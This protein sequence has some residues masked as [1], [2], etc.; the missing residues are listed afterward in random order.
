MGRLKIPF[1]IEDDMRNAAL[2]VIPQTMALTANG[3]FRVLKAHS[4]KFRCGPHKMARTIKYTVVV[5]SRPDLL[6]GRG[7]IIDWQDIFQEVAKRFRSVNE[8]P[9]CELFA[10]EICGIT[11]GLLGE[12]F[13][14]VSVDVGIEG[15]PAHMTAEYVVPTH[16][17]VRQEYDGQPESVTIW[18]IQ[19]SRVIVDDGTGTVSGM[20]EGDMIEQ[21][22]HYA[23]DE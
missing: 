3:S 13:T 7:F 14:S 19:R 17:Y 2:T 10:Q 23:S 15:L 21:G 6:D 8:F 12:R 22:R 9:P 4:T 1:S 11:C 5:K 16:K 18:P 20:G